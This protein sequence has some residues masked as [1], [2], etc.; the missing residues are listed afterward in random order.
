MEVIVKM[1]QQDA[2]QKAGEINEISLDYHLTHAVLACDKSI[3]D[4][5]KKINKET[6]SKLNLDLQKALREK[7]NNEIAKLLETKKSLKLSKYHIF[8]DYVKMNDPEAGRVVKSENKL[9]ISLP[10]ILIENS[11]NEDGSY[12]EEGVRKIREIMAHELG[13]IA[14]HTDE[15][16]KI[17]SLQG[18]KDLAEDL[19]KEARWF[20]AKLLCLRHERNR[21]MAQCSSF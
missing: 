8:V 10:K 21:K 11:R 7:D 16:L 13:H 12:S 20:S 4:N 3:E 2:E 1:M 17:D 6:T 19:E 15:L 14:L 9:I 5:Y 18:S